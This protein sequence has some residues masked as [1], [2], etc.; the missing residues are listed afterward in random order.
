MFIKFK[1]TY[2]KW[3]YILTQCDFSSIV[4][5]I[6]N[7][8]SYFLRPRV[9]TFTK[10][11]SILL[12]FSWKYFIKCS[13]SMWTLSLILVLIFI[14]KLLDVLSQFQYFPTWYFCRLNLF[15]CN[16][17]LGLLRTN[18]WRNCQVWL[19]YST[20]EKLEQKNKIRDIHFLR[21]VIIKF[22][23]REISNFDSRVRKV[24]KT[25]STA[26]YWAKWIR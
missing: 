11:N 19:K 26:N 13:I 21:K 25:K 20:I 23:S 8:I 1:L 4:L 12:L 2:C 15:T 9:I 22:N 5:I 18:S 6:Y 17:H 16:S 24:K 3:K 7:N 10:N 14:T